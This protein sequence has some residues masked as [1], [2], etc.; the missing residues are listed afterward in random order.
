MV[1]L[2]TDEKQNCMCKKGHTMTVRSS[3][4]KCNQCGGMGAKYHC[5]SCYCYDRQYAPNMWD[6]TYAKYRCCAECGS[7]NAV[8][9]KKIIEKNKQKEEELIEYLLNNPHIS[10]DLLCNLPNKIALESLLKDVVVS[11]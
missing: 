10:V 9:V 3:N 2:L 5:G 7:Q 6:G 8:K 11:T 1:S 4:G